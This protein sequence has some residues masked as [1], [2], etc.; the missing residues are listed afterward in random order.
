MCC[1]LTRDVLDRFTQ[2]R[3]KAPEAGGVIMGKLFGGEIQLRW[4]SV[5]TP[6]DQ[7]TRDNFE[8]H[9]H[10]AQLIIDYEFY[11]SGGEMIYLGEWHTHPEPHPSPSRTDRE[12]IRRP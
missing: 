5:P 2:G 11:N 6:L 9:T 7:A 10:S 1:Q 8:R 3:K 12:M 4:L